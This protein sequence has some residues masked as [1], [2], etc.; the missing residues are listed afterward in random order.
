MATFVRKEHIN[1]TNETFKKPAI[2]IAN[3]QSFIDILELL[4]FSKKIIMITNHWVWNSPVFGKIIQYAGFFH[5]DEGY[6]LCVER[7]REKVR[8]GYSI[9]IFPEGTRTYD[10]KMKRFHKGAFYL[11]ETLQ[12]DIIPILLYGN[13]E[14]IAKAQPFY[15]RKGI[16]YSKILPRIL[17]YDDSFGTTYQERTKRISSYMKEEYARICLEKNTPANPAFYEAL[18][19]NYIYKSPVIEWYIRIKVKM[20]HNYQLFNQLIPMKGQ[21]TDIGCG[22][23]PLCYMLS[24]ISKERQILGIDYDEDKIAIAQHGWLRGENLRFEHADASVYEFPESDV[25]ILNDVLHYLSLIH[26]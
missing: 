17:Y 19:L 23:G 9:A 13:G 3:H 12:L 5:V 4:S 26:I 15:V 10:G 11:S 22:L 8:E 7:M 20:E 24:M 1:V 21:I 18:V 2:I 25:F 16:I 14:I 6:E